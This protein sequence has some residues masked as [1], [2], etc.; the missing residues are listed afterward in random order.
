MPTVSL[1]LEFWKILSLGAHQFVHVLQE[2]NHTLVASD[3]SYASHR[4]N[5]AMKWLLSRQ[6]RNLYT[7]API[8]RENMQK[9]IFP[10]NIDSFFIYPGLA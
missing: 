5:R 4:Q 3:S 8:R 7:F 6:R 1:S 2:E 9:Q 10:S